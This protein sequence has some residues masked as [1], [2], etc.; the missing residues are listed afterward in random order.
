MGMFSSRPKI[1]KNT[2]RCPELWEDMPGDEFSRKC[3]VC[4]SMV[5]D[6]TELSEAE[7]IRFI[8]LHS[9][10]VCGKLQMDKSGK[11]IHG[12]CKNGGR[13]TIGRLVALSE[14]AKIDREITKADKRKQQLLQLKELGSR[15]SE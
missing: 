2:F 7:A 8:E 12:N 3:S 15:K 10:K 4:N 9:G 6:L 11:I 1:I 5:Y 14:D 13:A